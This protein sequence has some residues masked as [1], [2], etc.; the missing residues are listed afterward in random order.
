MHGDFVLQI[1]KC[2]YN[3]VRNDDTRHL[4]DDKCFQLFRT[5]PTTYLQA[6]GK[7]PSSTELCPQCQKPV[8]ASV[9][10]RSSLKVDKEIKKFCSTVR[11]IQLFICQM[12]FE[13]WL[14]WSVRALL[15]Q[16]VFFI[17]SNGKWL[18]INIFLWPTGWC[19]CEMDSVGLN[20]CFYYCGHNKSAYISLSLSSCRGSYPARG[21][22]F[23]DPFSVLWHTD[24]VI[25]IH[26]LQNACCSFHGNIAVFCFTGLF[27]CL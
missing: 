12:V 1:A 26:W 20:I 18:Q 21:L 16:T 8:P 3:I 4:C 7:K 24:S 14:I 10:G 23:G 27:K 13:S 17:E 11:Y 15:V 6:D 2:K 19:Y 25:Q 22:Y 9:K 5:Q